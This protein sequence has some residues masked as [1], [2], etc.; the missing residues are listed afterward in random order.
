MQTKFSILSGNLFDV[1]AI[2]HM[3]LPQ[4]GCYEMA[5]AQHMALI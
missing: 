1:R 2:R 3:D 4:F 5:L